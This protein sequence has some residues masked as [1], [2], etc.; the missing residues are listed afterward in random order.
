M[1]HYAEIGEFGYG[2]DK[3]LAPVLRVIVADEE[4]INS[5]SVGDPSL[6]I[7]T[8]Y[9]TWAGQHKL[10]EDQLRKNYA[11]GLNPDGSASCVYSRSRDA[12]I[13]LNLERYPSYILNEETCQF[14]PPIAK[15]IVKDDEVSLWNESTTSWEVT[16]KSELVVKKT[17]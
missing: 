1:A 10:G 12:F 16:L 15:P 13:P 7:Q 5:G 3:D 8:S 2:G 11:S 17:P 14:A 4:F 6:W 9:N